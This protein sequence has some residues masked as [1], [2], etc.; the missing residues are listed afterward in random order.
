MPT[1]KPLMTL[2]KPPPMN[3]LSPIKITRV[4][5]FQVRLPLIKPMLMAGVVLHHADNLLVRVETDNGQAGWG[6]ATAA[7]SHGGASLPDMAAVF[8]D[9]ISSHL[10]GQDATRLSGLTTQLNQ[11][12]PLTRS[13]VAAVDLALYDLVGQCLGVPASLLLGG[14]QR[15][16]VPPLWLIGTSSVDG[17][18]AEAQMRFEQG[19]RFFKL[20]L[21]VKK[22]DEDIASTL[23]LRE[24]FGMSIRLCGDAN[25]GYS[26][27]QAMAYMVG[28]QTAAVEFIE[29]PLHKDDL[30]GL[31]TL[32]KTGFMKIGLDESVVSVQDL[33]RYSPDGIAGVSLK[34][35]KLGGLSGVM[36]AG[37]VADTLGLHINIAG[38]I[39]ESSIASAALLQLSGVLPNVDWGVSPSHLYLAQDI[40]RQPAQPRD[41]VYEISTAPG[42]GIDVDEAL[43]LRMVI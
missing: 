34:T 41:G 16:T 22:I 30:K 42:L 27:E 33:L 18:L 9:T 35:L 39:A 6:E 8:R 40:V 24:R 43:V 10:I 36:A 31:R 12:L 29:Q 17:D 1:L 21:G 26:P 20:K 4:D 14:L 3:D 38:K 37:H 32:T 11:R 15:K 25:M 2:Q 13:A 7:P 28:V 23:A 5:T 19:Y